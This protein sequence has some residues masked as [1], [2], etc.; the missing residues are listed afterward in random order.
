M[1]RFAMLIL[2]VSISAIFLSIPHLYSEPTEHSMYIAIQVRDYFTEEAVHNASLSVKVSTNVGEYIFSGITNASGYILYHTQLDFKPTSARLREISIGYSYGLV[3]VK[4]ENIFLELVGYTGL[5][6]LI[7]N[8]T[9]V[10]GIDANLEVKSFSNYTVVIGRIWVLRGKLVNISDYNPISRKKLSLIVR[11]GL[12]ATNHIYSKYYSTYLLPMSYAVTIEYGEKAFQR[13]SR[14]L[15][16][17]LKMNVF[18][19][20]STNYIPFSAYYIREYLAVKYRMLFSE[21]DWFNSFGYP[22]VSNIEVETLLMLKQHI[23]DLIERGDFENAIGALNTLIDTLDRM[24]I[25]TGKVKSLSFYSSLLMI[26][27]VLGF[28]IAVASLLSW[29]RKSAFIIRTAIFFLMM[30]TLFE[31]QPAFRIASATLLERIGIP[32]A[33]FEYG[34]LFASIILFGSLVYGIYIAL[35]FIMKPERKLSLTLIIQYMKARKWRTLL[36]IVTLVLTIS[37]LLSVVKVNVSAGLFESRVKV[38]IKGSGII[39]KINLI[40]RPDG[41][42]PSEIRWITNLTGSKEMYLIR[43]KNFT[44]AGTLLSISNANYLIDAISMNT[45]LIIKYLNITP[46]ILLG[47]VPKEH[48]DGIILS[49]KVSIFTSLGSYVTPYN[50]IEAPQAGLVPATPMSKP[51]KVTCIVDYRCLENMSL[52]NSEKLFIHGD[53]GVIIPSSQ[54]D[55]SDMAIQTVILMVNDTSKLHDLGVKLALL[56]PAKVIVF[57][58]GYGV[59]YEKAFFLAVKGLESA[60]VPIIISSFMVLIVMINVFE[61]R[62]RDIKMLA[63]LGGVPHVL[64]QMVLIEAL[65]LGFISSFIGWVIYPAVLRFTID[66][67]TITGVPFMKSEEV[68]FMTIE[69]AY[70]SFALGIIVSLLAGIYPSLKVRKM[71]LLGRAS[72][73]V[74]SQEDLRIEKDV[75]RYILPI[76]VS[77]FE[78]KLLYKFIK[79]RIVS[80]KEFLSEEIRL[81]GTFSVDFNIKVPHLRTPESIRARLVTRREGDIVRLVL[82]LPKEYKDYIYLSDTVYNLEKNILKYPDWKAAQIRYIILRRRAPREAFTL[83]ELFEQ[84]DKV[85]EKIEDV[86]ER[87]NTLEN[88]KT[89][90]S[91]SLYRDYL[92]KYQSELDKLYRNLRAISLKLEPFYKQLRDEI[93]RISSEIEKLDVAYELREISEREYLR[94]KKPLDSELKRYNEQMLKIEKIMNIL[95]E[96]ETGLL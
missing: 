45:S 16:P 83:D 50:A 79:E 61:E 94:K 2:L 11:P 29:D 91:P 77:V 18:I 95:R 59:V 51:L 17:Y 23:I 72:R 15:I 64:S 52:F 53:I 32:I 46:Y 7:D 28:S 37:S 47:Y 25:E 75:A 12:K 78:T 89:R 39:V 63:I 20:N 14:E 56:Y 81:D 86:K 44:Y 82:E 54:T 90:I 48:E 27:L 74:I 92:V 22:I 43:V 33:S 88:I 21:I 57:S 34:A 58:N 73:K 3:P 10:K 76:K 5:F 31:T 49:S 4:I 9:I 1:N 84:A 30:I 70:L 71:T 38:N 68:A 35:S 41:F 62:R 13:Y 42:S 93:S 8:T 24:W 80:R 6:R 36:T 55:H 96:R 26:L 60:V 69:S 65:I 40:R 85:L 66:L 87:L 67:T 19:T